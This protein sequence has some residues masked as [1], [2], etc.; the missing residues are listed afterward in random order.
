MNRNDGGETLATFKS[1][2]RKILLIC[3]VAAVAQFADA[4]AAVVSS[5]TID[6][7]KAR[8]VIEKR[9]CS[10]AGLLRLD[11]DLAELYSICLEQLSVDA[12]N[13]FKESQRKWLKNRDRNCRKVPNDNMTGC[14]EESYRK[15]ICELQQQALPDLGPD[16]DRTWGQYFVKDPCEIPLGAFRAYYFDERRPGRVVFTETVPHPVANFGSDEFHHIES[17][18][19]GAYWVGYFYYPQDIL[20]TMYVNQGSAESR[21]IIDGRELWQGNQS[22]H[23]IP[24]N[25]TAGMHKVEI[26]FIN[27]YHVVGFSLKSLSPVQILE[28]EALFGQITVTPKSEIWYC[29]AYESTAFDMSIKVRL[30][31]TPWP[32]ILFLSSYDPVTWDF[33]TADVSRLS[34]VV[35]A[36]RKESVTLKNLPEQIPVARIRNFPYAYKFIPDPGRVSTPSKK[37][38]NSFKAVAYKIQDILGRKPTGF[39]GSYGMSMARIPELVLD[40]EKYREIGMTL[41]P[42]TSRDPQKKK[43]RLDMVFE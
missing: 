4:H 5:T 28:P 42:K 31:R 23:A 9:I 17:E 3:I 40:E 13:G 8:T 32:V 7:S 29:G 25:F 15:R 33:T 39:T 2:H 20:K 27:S 10:H 30:Q 37:R 12:Q 26:E 41:Q 35:V 24:A 18:N 36:S 19:F 38:T 43:S 1:I 6:C 21:I 34:Y 11:S 16:A 22:S 14:L